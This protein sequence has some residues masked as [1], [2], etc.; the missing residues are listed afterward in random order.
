MFKVQCRIKQGDYKKWCIFMN[1]VV[2]G[3]KNDMNMINSVLGWLGSLDPQN[4]VPTFDGNY[5]HFADM[6][7]DIY[8]E[9][10]DAV[11]YI[12]EYDPDE[13]NNISIVEVIDL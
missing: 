11:E 12:V 7:L 1:R 4:T 3:T 6:I 9:I 13:F 2:A 10:A 8:E 5:N